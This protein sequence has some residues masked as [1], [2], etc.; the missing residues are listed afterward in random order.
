MKNSEKRG[1]NVGVFFGVYLLRIGGCGDA[2]GVGRFFALS[3][4]QIF[5]GKVYAL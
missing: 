4:G 2:F 3:V 5:F 1:E